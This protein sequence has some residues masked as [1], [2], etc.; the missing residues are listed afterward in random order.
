MLDVDP[1]AML[2]EMLN[3]SSYVPKECLPP[4]VAIRERLKVAKSRVL[5]DAE[6]I[7]VRLAYVLFLLA[8]APRVISGGAPGSGRRSSKWARPEWLD[9][10]PGEIIS[11]VE[12]TPPIDRAAFVE[13]ANMLRRPAALRPNELASL[14]RL[15]DRATT[16]ARRP[17]FDDAQVTFIRR[18]FAEYR[19]RRTQ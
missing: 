18:M 19:R 5:R 12:W 10:L 7:E 6:A 8:Q 4:I 16:L 17:F 15:L 1:I 11:E 9:E 3:R 14:S 2:T 13:M